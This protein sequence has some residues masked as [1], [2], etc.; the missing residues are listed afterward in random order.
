M[1][2]KTPET[3]GYNAAPGNGF[4]AVRAVRSERSGDAEET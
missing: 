4:L 1:D 3:D 2:I